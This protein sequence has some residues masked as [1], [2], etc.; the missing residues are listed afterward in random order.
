VL[1]FNPQFPTEDFKLVPPPAARPSPR[2]QAQYFSHRAR[3]QREAA[4]QAVDPERRSAHLKAAE[5]HRQLALSISRGHR[6][7]PSNAYEPGPEAVAAAVMP[8]SAEIGGSEPRLRVLALM[9]ASAMA[10]T[11]AMGMLSVVFRLMQ[12]GH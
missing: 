3:S 12:G 5:L 8:A 10:V 4:R 11:G 7:S 1:H 9:T 6:V 2:R